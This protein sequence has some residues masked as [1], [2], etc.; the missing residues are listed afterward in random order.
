MKKIILLI[1]IGC[2]A[3]GCSSIPLK[4]PSL[5]NKVP[6]KDYQILEQGEGEAVGIVLFNLNPA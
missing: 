6:D 3:F 5:Q 4:I 1:L 2:F